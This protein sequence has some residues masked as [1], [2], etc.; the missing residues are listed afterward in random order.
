MNP[1]IRIGL[2]VVAL[3]GLFALEGCFRHHQE[4]LQRESEGYIRFKGN[5][6]GATFHAEQD[7]VVV[8]PSTPVKKR[9]KYATRPGSYVLT[10]EKR[11]RPVLR[12]FILLVDDEIT[13]ITVP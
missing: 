5:T 7:G 12:R 6:S 1:R 13:E 8:W 10:V 9:K 3:A 2:V 4:T 11:G